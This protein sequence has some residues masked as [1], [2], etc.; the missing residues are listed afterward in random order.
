MTN[1]FIW[2]ELGL[3]LIPILIVFLVQRYGQGYLKYFDNIPLSL[4]IIL[5][6]LWLTLIHLFSVLIYSFSLIPFV[7]F[8]SAFLLGLH[9]YDYIRYV[10][11]FTFR[12]YYQ[13]ASSYL[14]II[15]SA[16]LFGLICLRVYTY[17]II[18]LCIV[19][20][21]IIVVI[22]KLTTGLYYYLVVLIDF[23]FYII[24]SYRFSRK[25]LVGYLFITI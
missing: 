18:W 14:F 20:N 15:L 8:I 17:F 19:I 5:I 21:I 6:P 23:T 9:L 25:I 16:F 24:V 12:D 10:D 11:E 7:L 22:Y 1:S 2:S 4:S 3:Y 13:P